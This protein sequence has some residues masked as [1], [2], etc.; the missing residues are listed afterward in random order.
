MRVHLPAI[1]VLILATASFDPESLGQP[2][3]TPPSTLKEAVDRKRDDIAGLL[4]AVA[5][6]I[7]TE[8][9][10]LGQPYIEGYFVIDLMIAK[11]GPDPRL[12]E[13][14]ETLQQPAIDHA[15][16]A[17]RAF[18]ADS[19]LMNE[20]DEKSLVVA[21]DHL[22]TAVKDESLRA[23]VEKLLVTTEQR[24]A[25]R[26][27]KELEAKASETM[28]SELEQRVRQLEMRVGELSNEV[29]TLRTSAR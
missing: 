1:A 13:A 12:T 10:P 5:K 22:A 16:M 21:L 15:K 26:G 25:A 23:D 3:R 27:A 9:A 17:V 4:A 7:D 6:H 8:D 11:V 19:T 28:R 18:L 14:R 24:R 29:R 2:S 20:R